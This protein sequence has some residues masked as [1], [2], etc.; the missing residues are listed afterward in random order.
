MIRKSLRTYPPPTSVRVSS[1]GRRYRCRQTLPL[2]AGAA[3]VCKA[4]RYAG[5][6]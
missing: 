3:D 5:G 2:S 1:M 4:R 6:V